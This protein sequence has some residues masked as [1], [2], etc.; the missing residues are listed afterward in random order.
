MGYDPGENFHSAFYP[1]SATIITVC[2]NIS[3]GEFDI[4]DAIED[5]L[6]ANVLK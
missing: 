6:M 2:A 1:A 3:S 5:E 4:M